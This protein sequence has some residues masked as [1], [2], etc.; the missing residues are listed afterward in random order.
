MAVTRVVRKVKVEGKWQFLPVTKIGDKHDWGKLDLHGTPI[1]SISGTFYLD[2]RENG[3]RIRRAVGDHPRIA[4]AALVSQGSVLQL[5]GLGVDV[6][7]APQIQV[8][9][10][11]SG[12]RIGDVVSDFV[13]HPPLKLRKSSVAKYRNALKSFSSWTKNTHVSQL[14]RDD[15]KNFMSQLVNVERLDP[16]TA[17]DKAIIVQSV[18]NEHGAEIKM[19]K[20]DWPRVTERQPE[21]YEADVTQRLFAAAKEP[22]FTLFQTFL[23]TGFR[24]QEIG[25]L[26][27]EDFNARASTLSVSKKAQLGFDPKNYQER[28]IPIPELLSNLLQEHR[29]T[30]QGDEYLIFPTSRQNTQKGCPGGQRNRHMLDALKKIAYRAG[31]NC[32]RCQGTWLNK[33]ITC[34][35]APICSKFGLHKF[36]HT[37][38]TT[39]LRDGVDLVSL[40]KLMGHNDMDSTRKY[41]RALEPADLLKK[42]NLTTISTRFFTGQ[43]DQQN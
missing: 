12:K 15:L 3:Q 9:R 28:T 43:R 14:T 1:I 16:S 35:K 40:Q 29:K 38:A 17:V 18:M 26:A 39:L 4:K 5:R 2:Y 8:Y 7:D 30:Q 33:A 22:A 42:I 31:L 32:G 10:P 21:I 37:Y 20:G 25:F 27:W 11:V 23:M 24:D 13:A 6:D 19:K 34:A 36:R 41:L